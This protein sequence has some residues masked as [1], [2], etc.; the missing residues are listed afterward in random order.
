L[1]NL[2]GGKLIKIND[3]GPKKSNSEN[4]VTTMHLSFWAQQE[5]DKAKK[6]PFGNPKGLCGKFSD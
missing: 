3:H 6:K 5:R 2:T 1:I 4:G